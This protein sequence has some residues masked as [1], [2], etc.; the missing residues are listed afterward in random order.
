[1]NVN[2]TTDECSWS[3][4]EVS[5]LGRVAKSLRA[6]EAKKTVEKEHMYANGDEPQDI[7][8]GNK[9]YEGKIKLLGYEV[10]MLNKTASDAGYEDIT[11]VPHELIVITIS[12]RKRATDPLKSYVASGVGFTECGVSMEQG[13]K[14]RE[15]ELPFLAMN[16]KLAR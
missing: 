13:A 11:E 9:K 2:I 8:S 1:M 6:F 16:L 7:M 5:L 10:D 15:I 3:K 4:F 12:Y 14:F